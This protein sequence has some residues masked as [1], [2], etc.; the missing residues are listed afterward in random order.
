MFA[1]HALRERVRLRVTTFAKL[2]VC[3]KALIWWWKSFLKAP[4]AFFSTYLVLSLDKKNMSHG[5]WVKWF[6]FSSNG[7]EGMGGSGKNK[8]SILYMPLISALTFKLVVSPP[9]FL[10]PWVPWIKF[11]RYLVAATRL[12]RS[13]EPSATQSTN[14]AFKRSNSCSAFVR[15]SPH[16]SQISH[17]LL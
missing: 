11:L 1:T 7:I 13:M 5:R 6:N 3:V 2:W 17:L 15:G 12:S 10:W 8:Y 4:C 14:L 9:P 16:T